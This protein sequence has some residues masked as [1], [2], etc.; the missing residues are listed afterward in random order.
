M[1]TTDKDVFVW[2]PVFSLYSLDPFLKKFRS[3][4][5]KAWKDI[6]ES[7]LALSVQPIAMWELTILTS[8]K[9][10]QINRSKTMN[11]KQ[12]FNNPFDCLKIELL[13]CEI[14]SSFRN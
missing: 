11:P 8:F 4:M 6:P 2:Y 13:P 5:R 10:V 9:D 12:N 7:G 3:F 1:V 14:F